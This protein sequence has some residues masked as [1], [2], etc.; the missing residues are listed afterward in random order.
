VFPDARLT[1]YDDSGWTMGLS[2]G[3]EVKEIADRAILSVATTP[4]TKAEPKGKVVM[5]ETCDGNIGLS[6]AHDGSNNMISFRYRLKSVPMKIAEKGFTA[7]GVEVPAGSFI[8]EHEAEQANSA[9]IRRAIEDLGLTGA[10][11]CSLPGVPMHDADP[12]RIA[13]YSQWTNTQD[14]GWYRLAFDHFH[15]PYDLIYKERVKKGGLK[16]DYD[17]ILM[18]TQQINRQTVLQPAAAKPVPYLKSDKYQ[19]LGM[20][21]E[22]PDMSGGFGQEGVDAFAAFLDAG[23][24]LI[25]AGP[26][27]RFPIDF[28]WAHTVD[29]DTVTGLTSQRPIVQAEISRPD[30][31]V[32]YGYAD[33]TLPIKYVTGAPI[34]RVG[35]SDQSNVLG[36]YVGG[37]GSVLSGL[38]TG[39]DQLRQ[40]PLAVDIP[41]AHN[42]KGRVILFANNPI[43]RWQNHGEFN[44]I[45]N[46]IMN[47]N[48]LVSSR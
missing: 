26:S 45:F 48:D 19:F 1:T 15:I 38:M 18:A 7:S 16:T 35:S 29:T 22:S 47:W 33:K 37:D 28:G 11:S 40:R 31:A 23:G 21:G 13:I 5:N 12:P 3:V 9:E 44:M 4:V 20:Y 46:S 6:I 41:N 42:G 14:L 10:V 39:A 8:I 2:M 17:V 43:Y 27:A 36:R 24:T 25:A 32:F 30:H 34:L